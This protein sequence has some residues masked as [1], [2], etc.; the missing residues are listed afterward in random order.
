VSFE[1]F[2]HHLCRAAPKQPANSNKPLPHRACKPQRFP[3]TLNVCSRLVTR[4]QPLPNAPNNP[5]HPQTY[6][7]Y[8]P[9]TAVMSAETHFQPLPTIN[10]TPPRNVSVFALTGAPACVSLPFAI[11][12]STVCQRNASRLL[13]TLRAPF[14]RRFLCSLRCGLGYSLELI[15]V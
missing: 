14:L 15:D 11:H 8:R 4:N 5:P 13:L 6:R 12:M 9:Q 2:G 7:L 10:V 1:R 3:I